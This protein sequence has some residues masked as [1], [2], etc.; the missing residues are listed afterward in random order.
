MISHLPDPLAAAASA[1]D[2]GSFYRAVTTASFTLLGL[3]WVVVQLRYA[4]GDGEADKRRHAYGVALFFLLPGLGSLAASLNGE[5]TALWRVAFGLC[6]VLGIAEALTY[7]WTTGARSAG[8]LT[9]RAFGVVL[10]VMMAAVAARPELA[11]D[12]RL[13]LAPREVEA[14]LLT[15][16]LLV[17]AHLAWLGLTEPAETAGA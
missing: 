13:G 14:I 5:L 9:L 4:R 15:L 12:L 7:L 2:I 1:A 16:V 6:A 11:T 17:G 3:W 10:Y 8:A